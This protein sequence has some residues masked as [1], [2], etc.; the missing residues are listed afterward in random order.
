MTPGS[1]KSKIKSSFVFYFDDFSIKDLY[2]T[3]DLNTG[4]V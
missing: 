3:E 1:M 4:S 2:K